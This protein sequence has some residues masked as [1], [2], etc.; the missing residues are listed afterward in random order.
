MHV[1]M[2]LHPFVP[3]YSR[4]RRL[5]GNNNKKTYNLISGMLGLKRKNIVLIQLSNIF[6][7]VQH[8]QIRGPCGNSKT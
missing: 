8:D 3:P 7:T 6:I 5:G 1:S 2:Y 4:M